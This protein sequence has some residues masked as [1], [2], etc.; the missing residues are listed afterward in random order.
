MLGLSFMD[1]E[2][3]DYFL[4][5]EDVISDSRFSF[6]NNNKIKSEK[7]EFLAEMVV[8]HTNDHYRLI[9]NRYFEAL[10]Y[11]MQ[12]AGAPS[13]LYAT[14]L[15]SYLKKGYDVAVGRSRQ[16]NLV[17]YGWTRS[18]MTN[19]NPE[20]MIETYR[21]TGAQITW[22]LPVQYRPENYMFIQEITPDD[23]CQTGEFIILRDKSITTMNDVRLIKHYAQTLAE[24]EKTRFSIVLQARI[25]KI[26]KADEIDDDDFNQL[27]TMLYNGQPYI[28]SDIDFDADNIIDLEAVKTYETLKEVSATYKDT[29][30]Q[31][32]SK[33]GI[34]T[35]GSTKESGINDIEAK[36]GDGIANLYRNIYITSLQ[37]PFNWLGVRFPNW[38]GIVVKFN[39]VNNAENIQAVENKGADI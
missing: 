18:P 23:N 37:E 7:K 14:K 35:I 39:T 36:A 13:S 6:M 34:S 31:L 30:N 27:V 4:N 22:T 1:N 32:Y 17:V 21:L 9:C 29:E 19:T 3:N 20:L 15:N 26:L 11:L 10:P 24:I 38:A 2:N 25:S 12:Y 5:V 8:R 28:T 16:G 33:L